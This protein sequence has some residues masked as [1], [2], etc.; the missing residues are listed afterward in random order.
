MKQLLLLFLFLIIST[1]LFAEDEQIQTI[2]KDTQKEISNIQADK[3]LTDK[4]KAKKID[5]CKKKNFYIP[6]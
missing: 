1:A 4:E 6:T 2:F 3:M 5:Q